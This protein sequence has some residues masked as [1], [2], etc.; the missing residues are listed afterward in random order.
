[1][2]VTFDML[3]LG[4]M[5]ETI[6]NIL[7]SNPIDVDNISNRIITSR[8]LFQIDINWIRVDVLSNQS[9]D[10]SRF[11]AIVD[12]LIIDTF[13]KKQML[14]K[15]LF[16]NNSY[17]KF[18]L[19]IKIFGM[20]IKEEIINMIISNSY[21]WYDDNKIVTYYKQYADI[22]VPEIVKKR[23]FSALF[24]K[25]NAEKFTLTEYQTFVDTILESNLAPFR[26]EFLYK[27]VYSKYFDELDITSL[28]DDKLI[29]QLVD[30]YYSKICQIIKNKKKFLGAKINVNLNRIDVVKYIL[31]FGII[32]GNVDEVV[33]MASSWDSFSILNIIIKYQPFIIHK[34]YNNNHNYFKY[35]FKLVFA[36]IISFTNN[37]LNS[38]LE[39]VDNL[40]SIG[41]FDKNL[42]G[43]YNEFS[44]NLDI[45]NNKIYLSASE[46]SEKIASNVCTSFMNNKYPYIKDKFINY[47]FNFRN[48]DNHYNTKIFKMYF[49]DLITIYNY[50]NT[51]TIYNFIC[52][53]LSNYIANDILTPTLC[54]SILYKHP[55]IINKLTNY[56]L[57]K[58]IYIDKHPVFINIL[59]KKSDMNEIISYFT[60]NE[61][62]CYHNYNLL[63]HIF[64]NYIRL[65]P[66]YK[67]PSYLCNAVNKCDNKE[68]IKVLAEFNIISIKIN[69]YFDIYLDANQRHCT[70]CLSDCDIEKLRY[71]FCNP[72]KDVM[73][74]FCIDCIQSMKRIQN[75][76]P[77]CRRELKWDNV[78]DNLFNPLASIASI[79]SDF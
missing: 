17:E 31:D 65:Y 49:T 69:N 22:I 7:L 32:I 74:I 62:R 56:M 2:P 67:L 60:I 3:K 9:L 66:N 42:F 47:E 58:C 77:Y 73:H 71:S 5:N 59:R 1:M 35:F 28:L 44:N 15:S 16:L 54:S 41:I 25:K 40:I 12:N 43:D 45:N 78:M 63:K 20:D 10:L 57:I 68:L 55:D 23:K 33:N 70:I 72:T 6:K 75:T 39:Y 38:Y 21:N 53:L 11:S 8:Q 24:I 19:V 18:D 13:D 14:L 29:L 79:N 4:I 52:Y 50:S 30:P 26:M 48:C 37:Y 34:V 64:G 46:C 27:I 51:E 36:A 76:C 61:Q